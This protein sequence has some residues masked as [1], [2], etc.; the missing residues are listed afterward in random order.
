MKPKILLVDLFSTFKV[1]RDFAAPLA[2]GEFRLVDKD[3]AEGKGIQEKVKEIT[4]YPV[5]LV[6]TKK[7]YRECKEEEYA[8]SVPKDALP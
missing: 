7:G 3:S 6:E 8:H 5:C 2:S 1:Q 4:T